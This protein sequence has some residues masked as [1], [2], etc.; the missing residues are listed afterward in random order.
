MTNT[1]N[2]APDWGTQQNG[3]RLVPASRCRA[4]ISRRQALPHRST[5]RVTS[6]PLRR[7]RRHLGRAILLS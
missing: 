2:P 6:S 4:V 3:S 5:A 1:Q 7:T